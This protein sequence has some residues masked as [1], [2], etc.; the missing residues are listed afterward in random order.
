MTQ[1]PE[2]KGK[3]V[4]RYHVVIK[5]VVQGVGFRPY[6]YNLAN[7]LNIKGTVMNSAGGVII[8]TEGEEK[9]IKLFLKELKDNPP[10][11][12]VISDYHLHQLPVHGYQTFEIL[13]SIPGVD[14]EAL[15]PP[16]MATCCD[17][18]NDIFN[19]GDSHH[20]YP[21]T[22][23]TNCGPR[24][25]IIKEIPYDRP[26]TAMAS[27]Q[28]CGGCAREYHNPSDRRFHAQPVACPACGPQ[29]E[30]VDSTGKKVAGKDNWLEKCW[31]IISKGKFLAVK[32]LGGFHLTCDARN[33]T[34]LSALR[35]RKGRD[36]KPFALMCRDLEAV[37]KFCILDDAEVKILTSP[38]SPIVILR[39][40]PGA[41]LPEGLAP[42]LIT[43]GVMIPY[44]PLHLLLLSGPFDLLVM[45]SGNY[46][47]LPLVKDNE[48]ALSELK[49]IAH[50]FLRH[51]R[52]IVN[53]CD[54]SLVRVFDGET[55]IIRRSRGYVPHPVAVSRKAPAPV[56]LGVGGEMKNNFC[57]L[58]K[59][60]AF[61]SQYIGE[62]DTL[63][64]EENLFSSL[65]NF[66]KLIGAD[67]DIVAYDAHPGYAS[68]RVAQLVPS[69]GHVRTQHHHAH[70]ASCLAENSLEN[71]KAIGVILD[72]TGYGTDGTL[73]GFEIITGNYTDFRRLYHLACVPLPGGETAIRQP[74]RT[75]AAYLIS[76]L[77]TEG[78]QAA[79]MLF[80]NKSLDIVEKMLD[81]RFN[82]PLSSGCGRLFDAV[83]AITGVCLENTYEGQAAIELGEK[84]LDHVEDE[85]LNPYPYEI[86]KGII[87]PGRMLAE[88]VKEMDAGT[89]VDII[90][91]R[92]HNTLVEMIFETVAKVSLTTGLKKVVLS[93]G[94]WQNHYLF[95]KTRKL[96]ESHGYRVIYHRQVPANDGGIALGQ[97]MIAHWR[98]LEK[99]V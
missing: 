64:G 5:G 76:F 62:I 98:W 52:E 99:C 19:P 29:M 33:K 44:T 45:T 13:S 32:S 75:A 65:I 78:K 38:Q 97:V 10:K 79:G 43:L 53:R 7:V 82:S 46:S 80:K 61:M 21:F 68:A 59:N 3:A 22:N 84:V 93:G 1:K 6:V 9:N 42:G 58:K 54:D 12:S 40:K 56:I 72:G 23:C 11:L 69:C 83:S 16:D 51:N 73:W 81:R 91:T 20:L 55:H 67:P 95:R 15:V 92:F 74:W 57:L 48:G 25:T 87:L 39:K 77:G 41:T 34:S 4:T 37:R 50:Y 47:S 90:S 17:C 89:P 2:P 63:E 66:Q 30:V 71:D 86:K 49:G 60:Q 18:T 8:E 24:F 28:M 70:F 36:A 85:V 27:F 35:N 88:I 96:L 14:K 94:T 26:D 31:D